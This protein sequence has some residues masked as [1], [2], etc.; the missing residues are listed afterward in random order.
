[1]QQSDNTVPAYEDAL[2]IAEVVPLYLLQQIT[3]GA[4][5]CVQY[6]SV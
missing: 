4:S 3:L 5:G 6:T 1:M 2:R